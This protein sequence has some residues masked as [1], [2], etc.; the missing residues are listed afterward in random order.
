MNRINVENV[1]PAYEASEQEGSA[2]DESTP[3]LLA[4]SNIDVE[5]I[6][7]DAALVVGDQQS[8]TP[9][10]DQ[11]HTVDWDGPHD[12]ENP[13]NWKGRRKWI[14]IVLVSAITFNQ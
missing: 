6:A 7:R 5:K 3:Q 11:A 2:K 14:I 9:G 1:V 12:P 10:S 13:Q 8:T 4:Q